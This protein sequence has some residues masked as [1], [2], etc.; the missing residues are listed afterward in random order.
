MNK[1]AIYDGKISYQNIFD[2]LNIYSEQFVPGGGNASDGPGDKPWLNEAVPE[3]FSKSADDVCFGGKKALCV[4]LFRNGKPTDGEVTILK[5]IRRAYDN[6][7]DRSVSFKFMWVNSD[8]QPEWVSRFE[9]TTNPTIIILKTGRR[10]RYL[11]QEGSPT[12]DSLN[13]QLEKILGGDARFTPLRPSELP[14]LN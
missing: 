7:T 5:E 8:T 13:G 4:M 10:P 6:K 3:L 2:W 12:S 9:V 1:P 14:K 11:K